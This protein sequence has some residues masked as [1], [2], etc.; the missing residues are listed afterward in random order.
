MKRHREKKMGKTHKHT[1]YTQ[2][3]I[4]GIFIYITWPLFFLSRCQDN[5]IIGGIDGIAEK[6]PLSQI[7]LN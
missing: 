6:N 3:T 5:N 1:H 2:R 4:H 7:L